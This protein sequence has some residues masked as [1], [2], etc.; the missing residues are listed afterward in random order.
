MHTLMC[1][2]KCLYPC[3]QYS[4]QNITYFSNFRKFLYATFRMIF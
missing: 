4:N 3:N 1:F 2:D